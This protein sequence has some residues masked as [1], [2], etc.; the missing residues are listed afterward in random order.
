[1]IRNKIL[2]LVTVGLLAV[3]LSAC[4]KPANKGADTTAQQSA[5]TES[6]ATTEQVDATQVGP[7]VK[8]DADGNTVEVPAPAPKP[9]VKVFEG[10]SEKVEPVTDVAVY[11]TYDNKILS[12]EEV[13]E[14]VTKFK[15]KKV[16]VLLATPMVMDGTTAVNT[17]DGNV[18][19]DTPIVGASGMTK[20]FNSA[21]KDM[22]DKLTF[23]N[24]GAVLK[25]EKGKATMKFDIDHFVAEAGLDGADDSYV[26]NT[27]LDNITKAGSAENISSYLR[28]QSYLVKDSKGAVIGIACYAVK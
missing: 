9:P 17:L 19:T 15:G 7:T 25:G 12:G 16:A 21:G 26:T 22:S 14:A 6:A 1:M 2:A 3:S 27:K 23:V 20:I 4:G 24:Y 11:S 5:T 10:K 28:M 13:S 18:S 8:T